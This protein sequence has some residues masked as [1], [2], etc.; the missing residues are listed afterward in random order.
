MTALAFESIDDYLGPADGRFFGSGYRRA[1]YHVSDV[2]VTPLG[3]EGA[4]TRSAISIRYPADWSKKKHGVDLRPHLS[5]V[6]MLVLGV[7]LS[8][9]HL[10]HA[11]GLDGAGRRDCWL[12]KVT[13]RAGTAPQEDLVGLEGTARLREMTP[14]AGGDYVATY[15]CVI[16]AMRARCEIQHPVG[17]L[18]PGAAAFGSIDD[19]LGDAATRY[20]GTGFTTQPHRISDVGVDLENLRASG[21]VWIEPTGAVPT[22]GIDGARQPLVSVVDCFVTN[23]QLAQILMYELDSIR[24]QDS[25]TL[26]MLKTVL[27]TASPYRPCSL[28]LVSS[29]A[30]TG[31]HL[32]PLRGAVWRNVDLHG[33]CAGVTLRSSFVH[34][35]PAETL[36]EKAS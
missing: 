16:G 15:D 25:N 21:S 2:V 11:H 23:L 28:P 20:Y 3:A 12:R 18:A 1:E 31:K 7:Q 35:L 9:A 10:T 14:A 32:V 17:R 24:R 5:T 36:T 22:E 29:V 4:G 6:D 27:E 13:L 34:E 26:W 19:V 8:E 30:I 33:E